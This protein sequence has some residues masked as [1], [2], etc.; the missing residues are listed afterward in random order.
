MNVLTY[1]LLHFPLKAAKLPFRSFYSM[2]F[3]LKTLIS[4]FL[5][6]KMT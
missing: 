6:F 3:I 2:A 4:D 1:V 5:I